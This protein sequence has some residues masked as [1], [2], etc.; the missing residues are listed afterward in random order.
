MHRPCWYVMDIAMDSLM[1]KFVC[2]PLLFE[3]VMF[4]LFK[5]GEIQVSSRV[6][7]SIEMYKFI[8][9]YTDPFHHLI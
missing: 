3:R 2:I 1:C 9:P 7:L 8:A 4:E 5:Q 6:R